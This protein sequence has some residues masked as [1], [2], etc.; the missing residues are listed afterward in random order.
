M[1]HCK[2]NCNYITA[3]KTEIEINITI[4]LQ[5]VSN[6]NIKKSYLHCLPHDRKSKQ[7]KVIQHKVNTWVLIAKV[8][9]YIKKLD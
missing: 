1:I 9:D 6:I 3:N 5:I 7:K 4:K 8:L 2:K